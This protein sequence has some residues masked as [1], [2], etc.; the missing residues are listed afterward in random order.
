MTSVH[1][2]VSEFLKTAYHKLFIEGQWVDATG[3]AR[4]ETR[5]PD[6]GKVLAEVASGQTEDVDGP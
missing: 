2:I 5:D 6:S 1:P 3:Q 4:F